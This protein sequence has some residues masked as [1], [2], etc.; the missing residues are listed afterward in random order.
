MAFDF[1]KIKDPGFFKENRLTAHSDHKYYR[2]AEEAAAGVSTFKYL[3]NGTWKFHY[4]KNYS[5][6]PQGF[7]EAG[8]NCDAWDDISVPGHIQMQG[9][10]IPQYA[11]RQYPWDGLENIEPGEIPQ[12]F[13]PVA[14]Y[15]KYFTLAETGLN[16]DAGEKIYI[17]FQ[18][19]EA[20][21]ALWLNGHYIGYSTDSFTPS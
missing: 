8:Y 18:G 15:V 3:L 11:N 6:A 7:W 10:D 14:T 1:Y 4:A 17:S 5:L 12:E 19:V 2:S 13:N 21:F 9:Y 20:G 16:L